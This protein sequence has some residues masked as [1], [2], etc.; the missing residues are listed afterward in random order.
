MLSPA[1]IAALWSQALK[2]GLPATGALLVV[3]VREQRLHLVRGEHVERDYAVSTS[4]AGT[5]NVMDSYRTPTGWHEVVER[6]GAGEPAGRVFLDREPTNDMLTPEQWKDDESKDVILTRILRLAGLDEGVN[7]GGQVDTYSR[8]IYLHGA[9]HEHRLGTPV[10]HG[11][12]HLA[13]VEIIEL[14]DRLQGVP[15]WCWIGE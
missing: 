2:R 15:T 1:R 9:N 4:K 7:R 6:F 10:S 3:D 14:F 8:Y 11:C 12:I 5:G 13:N